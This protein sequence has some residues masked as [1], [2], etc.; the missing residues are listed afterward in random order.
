MLRRITPS[1]VGSRFATV[2]SSSSTLRSGFVTALNNNSMRFQSS[3]VDQPSL[4]TLL[5]GTNAQWLD[6]MYDNW[7]EDPNSVPASFAAFFRQV[8]SMGPIT[9][10]GAGGSGVLCKG[11]RWL[12]AFKNSTSREAQL[13][14]NMILEFEVRR[15]ASKRA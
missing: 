1:F 7:T 14:L 9:M 3:S 15:I 8:D 12:E 5:S 2:A 4:E 13:V 6:Q 10:T 11:K